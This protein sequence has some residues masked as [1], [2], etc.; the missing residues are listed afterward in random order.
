MRKQTYV[1]FEKNFLSLYN[2]FWLSWILFLLIGFFFQSL[3]LWVIFFYINFVFTLGF[4]LTWIHL[5]KGFFLSCIFLQQGFFNGM[6]ML[7]ASRSL[8]Q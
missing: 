5:H 1:F 3:T 2:F 6:D 7:N 4:F 8:L